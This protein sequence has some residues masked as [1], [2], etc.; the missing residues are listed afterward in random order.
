MLIS[1]G[2]CGIVRQAHW[3]ID[4]AIGKFPGKL[5]IPVKKYEPRM[6]NGKKVPSIATHYVWHWTGDIG[7]ITY[8]WDNKPQVLVGTSSDNVLTW[9]PIE[10]TKFINCQIHKLPEQPTQEKN[11]MKKDFT[12]DDLRSGYLLKFENGVKGVVFC[13]YGYDGK[14]VIC[15]LT[16]GYDYLSS[17]EADCT[18]RYYGKV[19]NVHAIHMCY[20]LNDRNVDAVDLVWKREEKSPEQIAYEQLQAQIADEETRHNESMKA[21]REQ[22]EKLKPKAV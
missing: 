21:L 6:F 13:D 8:S 17:I 2:L 3:S 11:I 14:S 18:H 16:G 7:F 20:I 10:D 19:V 5:T 15:Y 1:R 4:M 9:M 12:K 22:A